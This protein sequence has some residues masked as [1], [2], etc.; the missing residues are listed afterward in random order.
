M[1]R[2]FPLP[3][4]WY[5]TR[6]RSHRHLQ[7]RVS[8]KTLRQE[9]EG[10][11]GV[12]IAVQKFLLIMHEMEEIN[13]ECYIHRRNKSSPPLW[14]GHLFS[15]HSKQRLDSVPEHWRGSWCFHRAVCA[16]ARTRCLNVQLIRGQMRL[17]RLQRWMDVPPPPRRTL[18]S[19]KQ[20]EP[21]CISNCNCH[22]ASVSPVCGS[23]A[24]T[25]LSACFAGCTKAVSREGRRHTNAPAFTLRRGPAGND[26]VLM[27]FRLFQN[28][29][30]CTCVSSSSEDAVAFPGKCP[31]PGCQEAFLTF[32]C[33][34]CVCS[35]IGA[36]AQTP[37]VIILIRRVKK[38]LSTRGRS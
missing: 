16:R 32:L 33:V 21:T 20:P 24:V 29:T 3:G 34:I 25:Y 30:G 17:C 18:Q 28:L 26:N 22:T 31:S 11:S 5:R 12:S 6:S 1:L 10:R 36:M 9:E 19:R 4:L 15:F 37:S 2:V 35:M 8:R 38:R 7:Q 27:S 14:G 13:P 23:N